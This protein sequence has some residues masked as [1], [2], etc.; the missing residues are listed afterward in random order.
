MNKVHIYSIFA[1]IPYTHKYNLET[2]N[3]SPTIMHGSNIRKQ[4]AKLTTKEQR[5]WIFL[6]ILDSYT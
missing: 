3:S 6:I 2:V 4:S 5:K 1:F